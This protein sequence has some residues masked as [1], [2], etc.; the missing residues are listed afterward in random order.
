MGQLSPGRI[1]KKNYTRKLNEQLSDTKWLKDWHGFNSDVQQ[2][3]YNSY[4]VLYLTENCDT[5]RGKTNLRIE[6]NINWKC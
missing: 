5:V 1:L 3:S 2:M 4:S 6:N